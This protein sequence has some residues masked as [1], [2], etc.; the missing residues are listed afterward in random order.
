[1]ERI[2][3]VHTNTQAIFGEDIRE[4]DLMCVLLA[5]LLACI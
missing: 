1:M 3:Q 4:I 5:T 2:A